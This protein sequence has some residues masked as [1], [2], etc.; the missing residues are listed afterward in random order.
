LNL[1]FNEVYMNELEIIKMAADAVELESIAIA[2][3]AK[4][5][6]SS[7]A[8]AAYMMLKC[9]GH[10]IV[11]GSGTSHAVALRF[12]HLLSCSGTPALFLHP[13]DS[14]HGA[15]GAVR[16]EDVLVALSKGGETVEVNF[17]A[18]VA[19]ERGA[20]VIGI[21]EKPASTLGILCDLVLEIKAPEGVDP[22]GM[23][24]T[25]S[26]LFNSAF[27]DALCVVLLNLRGY[28]EEQ[29]GKTHPGG[30]VGQKLKGIL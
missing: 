1:F 12:A 14:Q 11:S 22:Y 20:K 28:S 27:C 29:F 23:I 30:A 9:N 19:K 5:L 10:I 6:K 17:L 18:S 7:L 4:Q 21:T 24:A 16:N 15:A 8:Q 2:S 3:L 25:G 13:G 26:S